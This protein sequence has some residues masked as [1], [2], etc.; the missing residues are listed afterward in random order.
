MIFLTII[1]IWLDHATEDNGLIDDAQEGFRQG[2][3]KRQS[4]K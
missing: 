1:D 4:A 3:T 2:R